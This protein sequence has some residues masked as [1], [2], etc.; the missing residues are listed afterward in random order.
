[1]KRSAA[2]SR[3]QPRAGRKPAQTAPLT[4]LV[5]L[6]ALRAWVIPTVAIVLS[7]AV[8]VLYNV[9]LVDEAFAVTTVGIAVL[10]TVLFFGLRSFL[11][12]QLEGAAVA[13]LVAFAVLWA[14]AAGYPFYRAVNPGTP[15]FSGELS[16]NSPPL[17]VPLHGRSGRYNLVVEGHF[18]PTEGRTNRTAAYRIALGR[19]GTT[20]RVLQGAFSETW[21]TQRIGSGRRSSL[22]PSKHQTTQVRE[23]IDTPGAQDLTLQLTELSP[24]VRDSIAVRLY[25]ESIPQWALIGLGVL[26]LAGAIV[27]DAWRPKGANEGLMTTMTVAAFVG[28]LIFRVSSLATP[29]FSQLAVAALMGTLAGAIGGTVLWRLTQPLKKHLAPHR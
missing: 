19:D 24:G 25:A 8:F 4:R 12:H 7:F 18:L 1:M 29:G 9:G 28:I 15:V 27:I 5:V 10:L 23:V 14:A 13:A 17:T 6:D 3:P 22:V 21:G 11:A 2:K 16:R 26:V 20:D